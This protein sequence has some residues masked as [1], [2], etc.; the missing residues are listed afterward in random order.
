MIEEQKVEDQMDDSE[1][2]DEANTEGS[3]TNLNIDSKEIAKHKRSIV[4]IDWHRKKLNRFLV[5]YGGH[6]E[7]NVTSSEP[8]GRID[9]FDLKNEQQGNKKIELVDTL[10]C[11]YTL[12]KAFFSPFKEEYTTENQMVYASSKSGDVFRWVWN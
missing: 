2:I 6:E 12:T 7:L 5:C 1:E 9:I 3:L 4:A 8:E 10:F 11:H